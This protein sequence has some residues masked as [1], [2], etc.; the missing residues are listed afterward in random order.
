MGKTNKETTKTNTVKRLGFAVD[1]SHYLEKQFPLNPCYDNHTLICK[2]LKVITLVSNMTNPYHLQTEG[3]CKKFER[4]DQRQ[5]KEFFQY[6]DLP[7]YSI[8]YLSFGDNKLG[9]AIALDSSDRIMY[10]LAID[11]HHKIRPYHGKKG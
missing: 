7:Q 5:D 3:G 11:E 4:M 10:F 9:I 8:H 6:F 1:F 2:V